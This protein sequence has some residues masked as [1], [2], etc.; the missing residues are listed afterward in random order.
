MSEII[1]ILL[2]PQLMSLQG[3]LNTSGRRCHGLAF[4]SMV[5]VEVLSRLIFYR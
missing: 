3:D 2:T 4:A 5:E 1:S